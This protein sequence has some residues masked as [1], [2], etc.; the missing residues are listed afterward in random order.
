MI[1]IYDRKIIEL[2]RNIFTIKVITAVSRFFVDEEKY[3]DLQCGV[4]QLFDISAGVPTSFL[5]APAH[6]PF[7][8]N[9]R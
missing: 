7:S 5:G 6:S 9:L 1:E 2:Q 3:S 4:P 8:E